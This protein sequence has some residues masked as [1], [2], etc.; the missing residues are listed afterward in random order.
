MALTIPAMPF[1]PPSQVGPKDANLA[2]GTSATFQTLTATGYFGAPTQLDLGVG[3]FLGYWAIIFS[4][5]KVSALN[6]EYTFFLLGSNDVAWGNG[7]VEILNVQDFGA[8][9]TIATIPGASPA[10]PT[11][12]PSG[13]ANYFPFE[14]MKSRIVYRYLRAYVVIAGTSPTMTVDTWITDNVTA[15]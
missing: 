3:R 5:R 6:E 13:E 12:G 7:N 10:L 15:A 9:R 1:N 4:A 2:F 14:N 8:V 11:V